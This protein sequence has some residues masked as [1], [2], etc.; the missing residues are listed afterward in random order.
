MS[1]ELLMKFKWGTYSEDGLDLVHVEL[2]VKHVVLGVSGGPELSLA[3]GGI[4][5]AVFSLLFLD[6]NRLLDLVGPLLLNDLKRLES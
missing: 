5:D 3:G 1:A 2:L 6:F 4:V